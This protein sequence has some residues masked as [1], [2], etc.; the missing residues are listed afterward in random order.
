MSEPGDC[1]SGKYYM[2][3]LLFVSMVVIQRRWVWVGMLL[4]NIK[5][6]SKVN[7]GVAA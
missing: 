7:E 3:S 6:G 2:I 5:T 4:A 1:D